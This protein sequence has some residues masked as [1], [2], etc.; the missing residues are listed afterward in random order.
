M[1]EKIVSS[2]VGILPIFILLPALQQIMTQ[3]SQGT[4]NITS[5]FN[6]LLPLVIV[7]A[8]TEVFK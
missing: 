7:S 6:L 2:L 4:F 3:I 1:A 5:L 8:I